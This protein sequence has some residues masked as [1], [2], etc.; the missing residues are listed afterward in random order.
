MKA[1]YAVYSWLGWLQQT[2]L[3]LLMNSGDEH[4]AT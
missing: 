3:E 4:Q 1:V 2:L